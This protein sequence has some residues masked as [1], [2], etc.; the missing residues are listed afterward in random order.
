MTATPTCPLYP[1]APTRSW[2]GPR[3]MVGLTLSTR[4]E[5]ARDPRARR[6]ISAGRARPCKPTPAPV[7]TSRGSSGNT[8]A[9]PVPVG[10]QY[11]PVHPS[12]G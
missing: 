10:E 3:A 7:R 12:R 2:E 8:V 4:P 9:A 5:V 6:G 1:P 11:V